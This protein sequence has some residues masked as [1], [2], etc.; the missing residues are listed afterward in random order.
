MFEAT[1]GC[2]AFSTGRQIA[3][4]DVLQPAREP[5]QRPGVLVDALPAVVL[6]V[7]VVRVDAVKRRARRVNFV[8][9]GEIVVDEMMKWLGRT[10]HLGSSSNP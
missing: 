7:I 1:I 3:R 6:D 2:S 4:V 9:I 8:K 5:G 10:H